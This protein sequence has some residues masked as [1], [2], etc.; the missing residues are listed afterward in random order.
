MIEKNLSYSYND[1]QIKPAVLSYIRHRNECNI[2]DENGMFPLFTAPMS[3][4]V[5][6]NNC[7][8]FFENNI[9]PIIPRT[10][11]FEKRMDLCK[12]GY[13]S[14][15]SLKEFEDNFSVKMKDDKITYR[16]LIDIANGHMKYMLDLIK[17][18]KKNNGDK[19]IVMAGN[20]A[21]PFAYENYCYAGVDYVRVG[22]GSGNGCIT[23]TQTAI[24]MSMGTLLDE[25]N[26]IKKSL[27]NSHI[28]NLKIT[29]IIADGGVRG[30]AD[31]IKALALGADY[32][33]V[34]SVF[35]KMFES[36]APICKIFADG[37]KYT[38]ILPNTD[39]KE[40][41]SLISQ[42]KL[43]KEYYGMSTKKAQREMGKNDLHTSEGTVKV[44]SVDYMMK[45]WID[46]FSDYLKS[47][48][49]YCNCKNLK[50]FIG[51]QI[52][53]PITNNG[54]NSINK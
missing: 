1:L 28:D 50:D 42:G 30:Y 37:K 15:F 8:T 10:I 7:K 24:H 6:E 43:Y 13:W 49:S 9:Y 52:L 22:I 4:V 23:S 27:I 51:N 54:Y 26:N 16:V 21:N 12:N 29:K 14:A 32:V 45:G 20:I 46:N 47:A 11:E 5:D 2:M 38:V 36:A 39:D 34:G 33:M 44:L 25:I 3:C 48:M 17:L 41:E 53:V 31:I 19:V 40:I 18:C 35:A